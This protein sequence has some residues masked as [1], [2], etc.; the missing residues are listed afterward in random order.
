[1]VTMP[2][3]LLAAGLMAPEVLQ[4]HVEA[5][6][7]QPALVDPRLLLPACARPD[8]AWAPGGRSVAVHCAAPEWQVFV[9][10]GEGGTGAAPLPG[11]AAIPR[12]VADAPAVRRGDRVMLEAGGDGFVIGMDSVAES[13]SR[14]GRVALRAVAGGRRLYGF[15]GSDG[16]VRLRDSSNMVNGR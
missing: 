9:P 3:L 4:A 13:D 6:A 16:H 2:L 15:I 12:R 8:F 11:E 7:G 5:F 14:D 1:M 10:V